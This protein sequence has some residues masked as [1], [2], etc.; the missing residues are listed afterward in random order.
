MRL[1]KKKPRELRLLVYFEKEGKV[2]VR[3]PEDRWRSLR[4]VDKGFED[5]R[6][7]DLVDMGVLNFVSALLARIDKYL[8]YAAQFTR[9]SSK[10]R[11]DS[12]F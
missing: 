9:T 3:I 6:R 7:E 8:L 10:E 4:K 2:M 5:M 12:L 1:W 11:R